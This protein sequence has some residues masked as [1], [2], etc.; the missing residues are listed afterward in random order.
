MSE[1]YCT[2]SILEYED[3]Y[4]GHVF[5]V[6]DYE[7]C[8]NLVEKIPAIAV[9]NADKLLSSRLAV[10]KNTENSEAGQSYTCEKPDPVLS[11]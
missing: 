9:K 3:H 2:I 4:E 1:N 10:I 8:K 7:S 6:G 11:K 5:H